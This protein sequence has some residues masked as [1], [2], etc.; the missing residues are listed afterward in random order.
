MTDPLWSAFKELAARHELRACWSTPI[1]SSDGA[2]LG[3]FAIYHR[4]PT[5]PSE[6]D[7]EIVDL[8]AHTAGLVIERER[9]QQLRLAAEAEL[10]RS[11]E[12]Q[13]ARVGLMFEHAPAG[14]AMLRGPDHVFES[15]NPG[16]RELIGGRDVVGKPVREALP[17]LAGQ[18]LYELLD[19][20]LAT[21]NPYVGRA[22][23]VLLA[24][25][26]V[27][28]AT[29]RL[30]RVLQPRLVRVHRRS[31]LGLHERSKTYVAERGVTRAFNWR[32]VVLNGCRT[33]AGRQGSLTRLERVGDL[34]VSSLASALAQV[35][36]RVC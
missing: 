12:Q 18:G 6:R 33:V 1:F 2:V 11:T 22:V 4:V 7:R 15:A 21:N 27:D 19:S 5:I 9:Q 23:R 34:L 14:I 29:R 26:C 13:L 3:T 35:K 36:V 31:R 24:R 20:V 25:A 10:R 30:H 32:F 28:G 8:L 17:E 16:Y